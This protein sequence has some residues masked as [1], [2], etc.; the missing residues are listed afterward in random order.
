MHRTATR[1]LQAF[2]ELMLMN[3][4][5][6]G[7]VADVDPQQVWAETQQYFEDRPANQKIALPS[8]VHAHTQGLG[9]ETLCGGVE[10]VHHE[11]LVELRARTIDDLEVLFE[12]F[13]ALTETENSV[14]LQD[15]YG[16]E[17]KDFY[18]LTLEV[19]VKAEP[20]VLVMP[21]PPVQLL[22]GTAQL[23]WGPDNVELLW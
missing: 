13:E 2:L 3:V 16:G 22:W 10:F 11:Y 8:I 4:Q 7:S 12:E 1:Y 20:G 9:P 15:T 19:R 14:R 23:T 21:V 18:S 17:S 6:A 5:E